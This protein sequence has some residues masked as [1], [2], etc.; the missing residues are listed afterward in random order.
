MI[1]EFNFSHILTP[2]LIYADISV[3]KGK[4]LKLAAL[5]DDDDNSKIHI[6]EFLGNFRCHKSLTVNFKY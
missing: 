2:P 6:I 3:V 4:T 5:L 1:D